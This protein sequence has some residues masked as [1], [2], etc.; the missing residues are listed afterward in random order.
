MTTRLIVGFDGSD[1]SRVALDWAARE[2]ERRDAAV[3]V[4]TAYAAPPVMSY[5][6]IHGGVYSPEQYGEAAEQYRRQAVE[7]VA[8]VVAEHPTVGIDIEV[9]DAFP[10]DP[11]L[12]G[13]TID[14][15]IV[16][17]SSGSGSV[18]SF[19]LGSVVASVLHSSPCPVVV[20]PASLRLHIGKIAVGIDGSAASDRALRWAA[21]EAELWSSDLVVVHAW[22]YPYRLADDS[23]KPRSEARAS[24]PASR[25]TALWRR[26]G[27]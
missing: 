12:H 7:A 25:S 18:K 22:E 27:S 15:L 8:K 4:V 16:V 24:T 5:Y 19:I 9:V 26:R 3:R 1:H 14:D 2:A 21:T 10:A 20:T 11:L 17:G 6:G 23:V 13:A